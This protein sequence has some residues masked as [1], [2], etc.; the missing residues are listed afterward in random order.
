MKIQ[1]KSP[2]LSIPLVASNSLIVLALIAHAVALFGVAWLPLELPYKVLAVFGVLFH[3][4]WWY[5]RYRLLTTVQWVQFDGVQARVAMDVAKDKVPTLFDVLECI[6]AVPFMVV[7]AYD[8]EGKRTTL[9][10]LRDA[11]SEQDWRLFIAR[12][13]ALK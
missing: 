8:R 3:L 10:F 9:T 13:R 7:L 11:M 2:T 12:C 4:V 1:G 6:F 5:S